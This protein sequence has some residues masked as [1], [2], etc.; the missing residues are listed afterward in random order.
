MNMV[1]NPPSTNVSQEI[2]K[3]KLRKIK[4]N[5]SNKNK[6]KYKTTKPEFKF[7]KIFVKLKLS[8]SCSYVSSERTCNSV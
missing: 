4:K 2:L 3:K 6:L 7:Y 1:K 8:N 5:S